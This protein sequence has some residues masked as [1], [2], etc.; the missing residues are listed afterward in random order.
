MY[1]RYV[2]PRHL[3]AEIRQSTWDPRTKM[4][5]RR[6]VSGTRP[7]AS[8]CPR[9]EMSSCGAATTARPQLQCENCTGKHIDEEWRFGL[10]NSES[11]V[12]SRIVSGPLRCAV[13]KYNTCG[14]VG[15]TNFV[16]SFRRPSM[17]TQCHQTRSGT[18]EI[19]TH[20]QRVGRI[21][22]G[23]NSWWPR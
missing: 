10:G 8:G 23:W 5:A 20:C 13:C 3:G 12:R 1:V 11:S 15:K 19:S 16:T 2:R 17:P 21:E 18:Q 4:E 7:L 9:K 22:F 6:A 14:E